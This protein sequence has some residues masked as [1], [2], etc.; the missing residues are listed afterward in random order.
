MVEVITNTQR[1]ILQA[2]AGRGDRILVVSDKLKGG[3]VRQIAAKFLGA[4]WVKEIKAAK[5]APAWR[6]DTASGQRVS[7][8]LTPAGLKA[9][10]AL[11]VTP[12]PQVI[13][14][15]TPQKVDE[16][17]V[18]AVMGQAPETGTDEL[19]PRFEAIE[20][21]RVPR[22]GSKLDQVQQMLKS[23]GGATINEIM[24]ATSWLPH[25]TR[26]VLTGLRKRG[27]K[28]TLF[29]SERNGSSVYRIVAPDIEPSA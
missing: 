11:A 26:A 18:V 5:D 2:A 7:L 23:D 25:S 21:L 19:T 9:A 10:K 20:S 4:G 28:L 27:Y 8:K 17:A 16:K 6:R 3:A 29:P 14:V 1:S 22:A 13:A 24:A 15:S 12:S